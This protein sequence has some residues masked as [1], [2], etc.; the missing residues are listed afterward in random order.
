MCAPCIPRRRLAKADPAGTGSPRVS[1]RR[2]QS[3]AAG[4]VSVME[5][6]ESTGRWIKLGAGLACVLVIL[7]IVT[8]NVSVE[9]GIFLLGSILLLALVL[10]VFIPQAVGQGGAVT[11]SRETLARPRTLPEEPAAPAPESPACPQCGAAVTEAGEEA[12]K[13]PSC[14]AS[15]KPAEE[16]PWSGYDM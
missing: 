5:R 7:G 2:A 16:D 6:D 13:C 15:L 10:N 9:G 14:G 12:P 8:G 1:F 11:V 3:G 4:E